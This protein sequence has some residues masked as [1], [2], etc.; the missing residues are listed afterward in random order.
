MLGVKKVVI[1]SRGREPP[2]LPANRSWFIT[3]IPSG[4]GFLFASHSFFKKTSGSLGY[5][6]VGKQDGNHLTQSHPV[7]E[8][9]LCSI[10]FRVWLN[11]SASPSGGFVSYECLLMPSSFYRCFIKPDIKL[12]PWS[13]RISS[14]TPTWENNWRRALII[15]DV[16][17]LWWERLLGIGWHNHK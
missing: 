12:I 13:V 16:V 5:L 7:S 10:C 17:M 2:Q 9:N 6:P 15:L 14:G 3:R 8:T 4:T 1:K 11:L